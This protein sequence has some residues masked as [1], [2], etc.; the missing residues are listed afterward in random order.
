M[1]LPMASKIFTSRDDL[2]LEFPDD[3]DQW[4]EQLFFDQT[5]STVTSS[6]GNLVHRASHGEYSWMFTVVPESASSDRY[7][8]SVVIFHRRN[9]AGEW[10]RQNVVVTGGTAGGRVE[11]A[12]TERDPLRALTKGEWIMLSSGTAFFRWYRITDISEITE[13]AGVYYRNVDVTGP[14]WPPGLGTLNASV[15]DTAVAVYERTMRI[16]GDSH[17]SWE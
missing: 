8:V 1:G 5:G 3:N 13:N 17:W 10:M 16:E 11:L 15:F 2:A 7:I 9:V 14:D 4:S 12:N 6:S